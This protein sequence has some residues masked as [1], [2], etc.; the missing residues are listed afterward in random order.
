[1]LFGQLDFDRTEWVGW[2]KEKERKGRRAAK[3]LLT[4]SSILK[5]PGSEVSLR[6]AYGLPCEDRFLGLTLSDRHSPIGYESGP[7][8]QRHTARETAKPLAAKGTTQVA[9]WR[10]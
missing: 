1:M 6:Y 3:L 7:V 2:I 4:T 9:T 8:S 10:G 5:G